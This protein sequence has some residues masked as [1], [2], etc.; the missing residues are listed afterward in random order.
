MIQRIQTLHL[1]AAIIIGVIC[2]IKYLCTPIL[3]GEP[4]VVSFAHY[5]NI[6][7]LLISI[8]LSSWSIF[9]FKNRPL[10]M[11]IVMLSVF[12]LILYYL[13]VIVC[14]FS[15]SITEPWSNIWFYLPIL[16]IFFNIMAKKRIKYDENLVR[17]ADRLR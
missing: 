16:C 17:S 7:I 2:I 13:I 10:Q 1:L 12:F 4:N 11:R 6:G 8:V 9:L 14:F 5:L 3:F 15:H